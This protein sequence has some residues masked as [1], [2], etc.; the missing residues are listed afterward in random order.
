MNVL[1]LILALLTLADCILIIVLVALQNS[2]KGLSGVIAGG[3]GDSYYDRNKGLT[4]EEKLN[5]GTAVAC[6]VLALLM[7]GLFLSQ[8]KPSADKPDTS[9]TSVTESTDVSDVSDVSDASDAS[10]ADASGDASADTASGS[11]SE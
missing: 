11:V 2:K 6:I 3:S 9:D 5:K 7:L 8:Y 1:T 10:A 4:K